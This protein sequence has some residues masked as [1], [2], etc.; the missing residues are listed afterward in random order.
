MSKHF[1][2]REIRKICKL[3]HPETGLIVHYEIISCIVCGK[4]AKGYINESLSSNNTVNSWP[5]EPNCGS[6]PNEELKPNCEDADI[7]S[8]DAIQHVMES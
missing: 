6:W 7:A 2:V 3:P 8:F 4:I 5:D 1:F